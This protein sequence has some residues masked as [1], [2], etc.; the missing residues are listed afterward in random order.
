MGYVITR[1]PHHSYMFTHHHVPL[2]AYMKFIGAYTCNRCAKDRRTSEAPQGMNPKVGVRSRTG[3]PIRRNRR[4]R[5]S[6]SWSR[7]Q[8]LPLCLSKPRSIISLL[9]L[10]QLIIYV[11]CIVALSGRSYLEPLL[12]YIIPCPDIWIHESYVDRIIYMLSPA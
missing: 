4:K 10:K 1:I 5:G 7:A 6:H 2:G 12:H 8:S 9:L 3:G 11:I